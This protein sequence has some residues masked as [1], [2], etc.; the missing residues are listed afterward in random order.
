MLCSSVDVEKVIKF[1]WY[2]VSRYHKVDVKICLGH[3]VVSVRL[4]SPDCLRGHQGE[5]A[6][7]K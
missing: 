2:V 4:F 1:E 3:F 7:L 6:Y 5:K